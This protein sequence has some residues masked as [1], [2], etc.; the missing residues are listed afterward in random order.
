MLLN[1]RL[2]QAG[3]GF[4]SDFAEA[5]DRSVDGNDPL[6]PIDLTFAHAR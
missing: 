2:W 5:A 6:T 1:S 4:Q 3:L